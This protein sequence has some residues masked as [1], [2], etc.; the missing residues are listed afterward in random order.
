MAA[1]CLHSLASEGEREEEE[2][3]EGKMSPSEFDWQTCEVKHTYVHTYIQCTRTKFTYTYQARLHSTDTSFE[4]C[5]RTGGGDACLFFVV[6][7][8]V[9]SALPT[10]E[11]GRERGNGGGG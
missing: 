7:A 8:E 4:G 6:V 9:R 5:M 11:G 2:D 1:V 3:R 10:E